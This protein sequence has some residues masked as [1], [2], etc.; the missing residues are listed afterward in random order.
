VARRLGGEAAIQ[1]RLLAAPGLTTAE[2][3]KLAGLLDGESCLL[4][5]PNNSGD[6]RCVCQVALRDDDRD[7]LV[8]FSERLG[9]G[10]LNEL[11]ARAGSRPQVVWTVGSKLECV[12]LRE[13]LDA[14]PLRGRKLA[15][16]EIWREAVALWAARGYGFAP[17]ARAR[18]ERLAVQLKASRAYREPSDGARPPVLTDPYGPYYFAG[19]F[20][21][22]GS[23]R[24]R[25][26]RARFVVKLRRDDR[27][28]LTAFQRDFGIGSVCDVDVPEHWSPATVWHVTAA[29][30]VLKGI[31]MFEGAGLLGRKARQF[32]AWRPGAEAVARA[33]VGSERVDDEVV[34]RARRELARA[35]AYKSPASPLRR[36]DGRSGARK[37]YID[38]LRAWAAITDGPLT[39]TT[40]RA[41]RLRLRPDWPKRETIAFAFGG[42]HEALNAA[43]L[44]DRATSWRS[45]R[46]LRV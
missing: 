22:E 19:F 9:L 36:D 46:Q 41:A 24:V 42:W 21:G 43:G 30:D 44:A 20:S 12:A 32:A 11:P 27:P 34:A 2:S 15:E 8:R 10:H 5:A 40:Y 6:W 13:L 17:G 3:H 23:F 16:Y 1:A 7:T 37:A 29:R 14:H 45:A 26:R 31:A 18:L 39:C 35:T 4:L 33:I 28:L 25:E 38:V